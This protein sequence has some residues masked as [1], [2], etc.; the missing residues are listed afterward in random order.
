MTLSKARRETQGIEQGDLVA[1]IETDDG[2]LEVIP[3]QSDS[4]PD[5]P[6]PDLTSWRSTPSPRVTIG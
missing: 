1:V 5:Y 3:A 6:T 4:E 2:H